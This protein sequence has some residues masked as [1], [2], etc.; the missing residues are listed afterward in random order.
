MKCVY[1]A[2]R[3]GRRWPHT[4]PTLT[5]TSYEAIG[6]LWLV[7]LRLF[8]PNREAGG[9]A[10]ATLRQL[11]VSLMQMMLEERQ[12][13][14]LTVWSSPNVLESS[15]FRRTTSGVS[16]DASI[17]WDKREVPWVLRRNPFYTKRWHHNYAY[18][19]TLHTRWRETNQ[20]FWLDNIPTQ[21]L[22]T[23]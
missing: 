11:R 10:W 6:L 2:Q 20:G 1:V 12:R 19:G 16:T 18:V 4:T 17:S 8:P 22:R 23:E 14:W 9:G 21:P 7:S 15:W 3:K 5:V 13:Y